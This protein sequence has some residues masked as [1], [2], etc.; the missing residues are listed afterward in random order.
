MFKKGMIIGLLLCALF[1]GQAFAD[2][3]G[4][5]YYQ[6]QNADHWLRHNAD[7]DDVRAKSEEAADR[8]REN[9]YVQRSRKTDS[10]LQ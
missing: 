8:L 3:Q 7:S 4:H 10:G 5:E 9:D 6:P 1:S 2:R